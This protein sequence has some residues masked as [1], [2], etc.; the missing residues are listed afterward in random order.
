MRPETDRSF[1]FQTTFIILML[2]LAPALSAQ[3]SIAVVT[4]AADFSFILAPGEL[5][6]IFGANLAVSQASATILPIPT[7]LNGVSITI[8]G[9]PAPVYYVSSSQINFQIPYATEP[10]TATVSVTNSGQTGNSII[11]PVS[12]SALGIF[13][14]GANL[15]VIQNQDYSLNSPR[16]AAA[17]GSIITA[18]LTGIGLT[19]TPVSDGAPAR[20]SP[21]A[22]ARTKG[23][24]KIGDTDALVLFLGLTPGNVGLAQANVQIPLIPSGAYPLTITLDGHPSSSV[25]ISIQSAGL[26]TFTA[27]NILTPMAS[28]SVPNIVGARLVGRVTGVV[29]GSI[30]VLRNYLYLCTPD[31]IHVFDITNPSLPNLLSKFGDQ[32][33]K[34]LGNSCSVASPTA[35]PYLVEVTEGSVSGDDRV[36]VYDLANPAMPVR[37]SNE[38]ISPLTSVFSAAVSGSIGFFGEGTFTLTGSRITGAKGNIIAV[39]FSDRT[40]PSLLSSMKTVV[41]QPATETNHLRQG[42]S[43]ASPTVLYSGSTTATGAFNAQSTGAVDIFDVSNPPNIQGISRTLIPGTAIVG[44]S[45]STSG[46]EM[47]VTGNTMGLTSPGYTAPNGYVDYPIMGNLTLTMFNITDVKHPIMQG[48]VVVPFLRPDSAG[49]IS[50]P[51]GAGFYVL[52]CPAPDITGTGPGINNSIVIVDARE[53]QSPLAYTYGTVQGLGDLQVS[54]GYLYAATLSGLTVYKINLP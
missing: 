31:D 15:G 34:G 16:N 13:Q 18:Y 5:A 28:L 3:P 51:L 29:T 22:S 46:T 23:T 20:S 43:L 2:T 53:P 6:T 39:D 45:K 10:G 30:G 38:S 33:I 7:T 9:R 8:N 26:P 35:N 54:N 37:K 52:S 12:A 44:V 24:A 21:P 42:F 19:D 17:A 1:C 49:C 14:Y 41:S 32:D 11:V 4:N 25:L 50:A 40:K 48:N 27:T 36:I 47:L